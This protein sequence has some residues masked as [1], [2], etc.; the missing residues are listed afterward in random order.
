MK[1][2]GMLILAVTIFASGSLAADRNP[3]S[4][5][6]TKDKSSIDCTLNQND[7]VFALKKVSDRKKDYAAG[8]AE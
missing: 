6:Q 2:L 4:M 3:A 1:T 7:S 5:T 8:K